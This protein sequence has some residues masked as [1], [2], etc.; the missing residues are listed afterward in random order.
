MARFS[1]VYNSDVPNTDGFAKASVG[2]QFQPPMPRGTE[3]PFGLRSLGCKLRE[4][5]RL[6]LTQRPEV[7]LDFS[8]LTPVVAR[9][10]TLADSLRPKELLLLFEAYHVHWSYLPRGSVGLPFPGSLELSLCP[11][12]L[13]PVGQQPSLSYYFSGVMEFLGYANPCG[14]SCSTC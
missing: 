5:R 11:F 1:I 8:A 13:I 9:T 6:R 12:P 3:I 14:A 2:F 7:W 10:T 4:L